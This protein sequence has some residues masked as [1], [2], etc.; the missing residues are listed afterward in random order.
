[1]GR[2]LGNWLEGSQLPRDTPPGVRLGLPAD[3]PGSAVG[4]GPRLAA[5]AVD[6]IIANLLVGVPVLF[7]LRYSVNARGLAV[8]LAFLLEEFILIAVNGQT[9]GMRMLGVRVIRVRDHRP[10]GWFWSAVRTVLLAL[11]VPAF[12]WDR[13]LRGTHDR[14]AGTVVIRDPARATSGHPASGRN[15]AER[16][17][18][19]GGADRPAPGQRRPAQRKP[20]RP[21]PAQPRPRRRPDPGAQ[22]PTHRPAE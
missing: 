2:A 18:G 19:R 14:A 1:M 10:A 13:D 8:Y 22:R 9:I 12:I 17:P 21:D 5:F 15:G 3:G 11:A 20:G 6:A 7:G 4:A 16:T